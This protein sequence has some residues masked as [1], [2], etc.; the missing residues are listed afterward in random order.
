MDVLALLS[1][2]AF[3]FR[4]DD[5]DTDL[6]SLGV[7][8]AAIFD[9]HVRVVQAAHG[10]VLQRDMSIRQF[11]EH[12]QPD[13]RLTGGQLAQAMLD[14][15][16]LMDNCPPSTRHELELAAAAAPHGPPSEPRPGVVVGTMRIQAMNGWRYTCLVTGRFG[17]RVQYVSLR[18]A[19][20]PLY[21]RS[22][23]AFAE[24]WAGCDHV[25]DVRS[26]IALYRLY[27]GFVEISPEALARLRLLESQD[28]DIPA[29]PLPPHPERVA[30]PRRVA[31][32]K[33]SPA[34]RRIREMIL[35][36][37]GMPDDEIFATVRQRYKLPHQMRGVVAVVRRQMRGSQTPTSAKRPRP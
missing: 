7:V 34:S 37:P 28:P 8:A 4:W 18:D 25:V 2:F 33:R 6:S 22:V 14:N 20:F 35:A 13:F 24:E 1:R 31:E 19:G 9:R 15:P 23:E 16:A 12:H 27:A 30:A 29:P 17:G 26:A 3:R 10:R 21:R 5:A 32:K 36:D 11:V